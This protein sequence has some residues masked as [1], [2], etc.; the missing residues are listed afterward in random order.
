MEPYIISEEK[1][2]LLLF[3]I[4]RPEKRNAVNYEVMDGLEKAIDRAAQADIKALGI[5]G[6]G[7]RAFCSGGDLSAFHQLMTEEQAYEMLSRM[8]GILYNILVLPK[9]TVAVLNGTA[10]GGGCELAMA[11]DYRI[12]RS[13]IKAGFVQGNLA[14]TTG[15]GGG[16]ILFEKLPPSKALKM[17]TDAA[18]HT[19]DDLR[20]LGYLDGIYEGTPA[21]GCLSFLGQTLDK[22]VA[23]LQSFKRMLIK[24]WSA[25][26]IRERIEEEA[27]SCAVLWASEAHHLKV[28]QFFDNK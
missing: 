20:D 22:E 9:P 28:K 16:T 27:R 19:A 17:V 21:D 15:W 10:V 1:P 2:G 6:A 3:T 4:N 11:C 8:S 18:L 14:I 26:K 24:K 5:T 13:G 7:S 23:V 12:G 25:A